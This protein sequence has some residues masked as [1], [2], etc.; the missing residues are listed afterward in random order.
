MDRSVYLWHDTI[1]KPRS[2]VDHIVQVAEAIL[3]L[4]LEF[5]GA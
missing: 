1:D 3:Q 5:S 2:Y 4:V